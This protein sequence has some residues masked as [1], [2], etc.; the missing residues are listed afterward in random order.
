MFHTFVPDLLGHFSTT[1]PIIDSYRRTVALLGGKPK[2]LEGWKI[3][4]DGAAELMARLGPQ[5]HFT[6]EELMHRR[7]HADTPYPSVSR[8]L[9]HGGGQTVCSSSIPSPSPLT[10]FYRNRENFVTT[11]S[12]S[13][14]P[15]RCWSTN[16]FAAS[17][18][19]PIVSFFVLLSCH[20]I[21]ILSGLVR[22]FA[23]FLFLF[24]QSQMAL[25][26]A[27]NTAL[28]FPF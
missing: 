9:S 20:S 3:V 12:T 28:R 2:D 17:W 6:Y 24:Y 22:V 26:A 19:L 23:P 1:I 16:I 25:L 10:N 8:G 5:G 18:A 7:A 11:P 13:K 14:S 27:W 21:F 15:T 4:T